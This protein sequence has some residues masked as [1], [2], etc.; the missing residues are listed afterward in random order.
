MSLLE[1][2]RRDIDPALAARMKARYLDRMP[3]LD[4]AAFETS[5]TIL[6]AQRHAKVIGIFTRLARRDGKAGYLVHIPRVWGLLERSLAHPALAG[7]RDWL[8]RAIPADRR[9]V[10][11]P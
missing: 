1:D 3:G 2:A 6:A 7:I 5:W 10:P 11:A 8:D 4:R 9:T